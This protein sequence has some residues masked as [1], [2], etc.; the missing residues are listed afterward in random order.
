MTVN[1]NPLKEAEVL[2]Y[3]GSR[4]ANNALADEEVEKR[5]QAA[6]KSFESLHQRLWSRQYVKLATKMKVYNASVIHALFMG[7]RH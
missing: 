1:E 5:T 6:N 3:L 7:Q 4:V 2:T